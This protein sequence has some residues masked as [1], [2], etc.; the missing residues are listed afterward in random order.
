MSKNIDSQNIGFGDLSYKNA[1][2]I[3]D[4]K[5]RIQELP[6]NLWDYLLGDL[7]KYENVFS[8]N[9]T[10]EI[11]KYNSWIHSLGVAV[12]DGQEKH[13]LDEKM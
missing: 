4:I 2:L 13:S 12:R 6:E 1:F 10:D 9:V 11:T 7:D 3:D 8:G 5:K